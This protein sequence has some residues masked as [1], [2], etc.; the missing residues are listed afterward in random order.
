MTGRVLLLVTLCMPIWAGCGALQKPPKATLVDLRP[1]PSHKSHK[2][3][4]SR[5]PKAAEV[6]K[7]TK[8][9]SKERDAAETS[10]PARQENAWLAKT[11]R[12]IAQVAKEIKAD[13]D[14]HE[15]EGLEAF[16][17]DA[18]EQVRALRGDM[19]GSSDITR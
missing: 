2:T 6:I 18:V 9:H 4:P 12:Q 5:T 8:S 10:E 19:N 1:K 3:A 13:L 7:T 17:P 11:R 16:S 15:T 14:F